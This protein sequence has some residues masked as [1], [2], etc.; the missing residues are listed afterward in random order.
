M[1][2]PPPV[3]KAVFVGEGEAVDYKPAVDVKAG[4]VKVQ[5][6]LVGVSRRDIPAGTLGALAVTGVFDFPKASGTGAA[7][8]AG[9]K[10]Y[11]DA[12]DGF[13]GTDEDGGANKFLGKAVRAASNDDAEVRVRL[14]Q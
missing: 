6:E 1:A 11:W 10:V 12:D 2:L 13:A 7:I 4:E 14:S 9:S 8:A 5:G 3:P